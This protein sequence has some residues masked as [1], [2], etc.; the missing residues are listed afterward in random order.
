[1][2]PIQ[3]FLLLAL[4]ASPAFSAPRNFEGR[5][6]RYWGPAIG[7]K[8]SDD[9]L[10]IKKSSS[11]LTGVYSGTDDLGHGTAYFRADITDIELS[12]SGTISFVMPHYDYYA[13]PIETGEKQDS[14]GGSSGG[15]RYVG[16]LKGRD[17]EFVCKGRVS[18]CP[19]PKMIFKR[20]E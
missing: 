14:I 8:A 12:P 13:K 4:V 19:E 2:K 3:I 9:V 5:F 6:Q 18:Q 11:K 17:I 1:M 15:A 20:I 10:A 7:N 16:T